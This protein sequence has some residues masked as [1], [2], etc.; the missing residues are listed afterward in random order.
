MAKLQ[1]S[2]REEG[3]QSLC[4]AKDSHDRLEEIYR[5]H[6]DFTGIDDLTNREIERWMS[7]L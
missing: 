2:L 4:E 6:V 7:W 1:E 5:P 3:I